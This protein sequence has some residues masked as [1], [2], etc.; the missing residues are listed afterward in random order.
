MNAEEFVY[1]ARSYGFYMI[2]REKS[3]EGLY[4]VVARDSKGDGMMWL[5][6]SREEGGHISKNLVSLIAESAAVQRVAD[7]I[8]AG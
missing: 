5:G 2:N 3:E 8:R 1:R 7:E 4:N 6:E